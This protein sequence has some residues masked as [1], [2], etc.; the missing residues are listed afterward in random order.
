MENIKS[1]KIIILI[2]LDMS[3]IVHWKN[4]AITVTFLILMNV[5]FFIFK[6]LHISIIS[7]AF[8][9]LFYFSIFLVIKQQLFAKQEE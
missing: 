8:T 6:S 3:D 7:S 5:G 9:K 2:I 1:V 4:P